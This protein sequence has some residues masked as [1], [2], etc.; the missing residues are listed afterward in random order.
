MSM[1]TYYLT[2]TFTSSTF[3]YELHLRT[4][5]TNEPHPKAPLPILP[6]FPKST[7]NNPHPT[8]VGGAVR[9]QVAGDLVALLIKEVLDGVGAHLEIWDWENSP[10]FSVRTIPPPFPISL[11]PN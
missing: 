6:C 2:L 5:S 3:V 8:E 11:Q 9:V 10:Q 4:L 7:E 1:C